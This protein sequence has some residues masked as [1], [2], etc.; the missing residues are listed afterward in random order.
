MRLCLSLKSRLCYLFLTLILSHCHCH[1]SRWSHYIADVTVVACDCDFRRPWLLQP[2]MMSFRPY[3]D[4]ENSSQSLLTSDRGRVAAIS[5]TP[6]DMLNA[7]CM[8]CLAQCSVQVFKR[9]AWCRVSTLKK[10]VLFAMPHSTINKSIT[11]VASAFL[12]D[13]FG[14]GH[15]SDGFH[16]SQCSL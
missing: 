14:G 15:F 7:S 13:Y 2:T 16:N 9:A 11:T 10:R 3:V 5:S 4:K 8:R 1:W 6:G 12:H